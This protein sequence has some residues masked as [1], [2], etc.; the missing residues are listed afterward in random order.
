VS[1]RGRRNECTRHFRG[2]EIA[3]LR[4]GI[5]VGRAPLWDITAI[6]ALAKVVLKFRREGAEVV[7]LDEACATPVERFAIHD[8]PGAVEQL[9]R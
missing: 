7:G 5:G 9:T 1:G 4:R 3:R 8:K 2:P 6:S